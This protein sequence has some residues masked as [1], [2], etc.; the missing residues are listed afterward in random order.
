MPTSA[1]QLLRSRRTVHRFEPRP[2]PEAIVLEAIESARWAPNH[3]LTEPWEFVLIGK[4]TAAAIAERNADMLRQ[5]NRPA[6]ADHKLARWKTVPGWMLLTCR[7]S[8]DAFRQQEDFAA[9]CCAAQN[10]MLSLWGAGV[11]SKWTSGP[12]TEDL[13]FFRIVDI[14]PEERMV[15]GLFWYGYAAEVPVPTR[16]PLE[17]VTRELL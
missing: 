10:F 15:V 14:K 12:V 7:R 1:D 6:K 16:G 17:A 13:E 11:A 2:V 8:E 4:E 5:E 9:C 3:K